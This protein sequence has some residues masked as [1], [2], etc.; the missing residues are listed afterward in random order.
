MGCASSKVSSPPKAAKRQRLYGSDTHRPNQ[1]YLSEP[2]RKH[3]T[4]DV[5]SH[6]RTRGKVEAARPKE[7]FAAYAQRG[8]IRQSALLPEGTPSKRTD[9]MAN[10]K[11]VGAL[12][13]YTHE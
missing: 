6:P 3:V 5:P 2:S 11:R 13:K 4:F 9:R 1:R 7:T 8:L 10:K 12:E